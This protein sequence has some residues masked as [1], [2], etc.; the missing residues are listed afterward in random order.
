MAQNYIQPGDTVTC[1]APTGGTVSGVP[2]LNGTAGAGKVVVAL[3]TVAVGKEVEC[4]IG[5]VYELVKTPTLVV[6]TFD[7]LYW[8]NTAKQVNK[9][10]SG[11]TLMGFAAKDEIAASSTVRVRLGDG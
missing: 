1:I 9:T 5:G 4:A 7:L 2:F 11:N 3:Q 10:A 8:D 6:K